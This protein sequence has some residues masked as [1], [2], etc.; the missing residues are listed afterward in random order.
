MTALL[1]ESMNTYSGSKYCGGF[2]GRNF[3]GVEGPMW[4]TTN[5][6]PNAN[7]TLHTQ[8]AGSRERC[9][10]L[11]PALAGSTAER[12]TSTKGYHDCEGPLDTCDEGRQKSHHQAALFCQM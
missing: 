7:A 6:N 11:R 1:A 9:P 2:L 4:V 5:Q 3:P 12:D 8:R 10:A